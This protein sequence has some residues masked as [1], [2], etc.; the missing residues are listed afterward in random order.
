[1]KTVKDLIKV[2]GN[3]A[4]YLGISNLCQTVES[5]DA[6]TGICGGRLEAAYQWASH[7]VYGFSEVSNTK[8]T[9]FI[10]NFSNGTEGKFYIPNWVMNIETENWKFAKN[11]FSKYLRSKN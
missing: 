11:I 6:Y 2:D 4:F 10:V 7:N 9:G 8:Y 5:L 3:A 1:M